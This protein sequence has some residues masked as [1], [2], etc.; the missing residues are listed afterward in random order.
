MLLYARL[1]LRAFTKPNLDHLCAVRG[2]DDSSPVDETRVLDMGC[3]LMRFNFLHGDLIR[4]LGGPYTD[5]HRDWNSVFDQLNAVSECPSPTGYAPIDYSRVYRVCTEGIP[6]KANITASFSSTAERN[7]AP[8]S[9]DLKKNATDCDDKVRAEEKLSYQVLFPRFLWRFIPGLFLCLLR[10][11]YRWGDPKAR[12]CVDPSSTISSSDTGNPNSQIGSPGVDPE[13]NPPIYY[14]TA[15]LRYLVW[16]WNLRCSYPYQ[17]I[18]QMTNDISGAFRRVLYHPDM[19]TMFASVWRHYLV[20]PVG[21]IFGARNSPSF[22]MEKGEMRSHFSQNHPD[23]ASLPLMELTKTLQLPPDPTTEEALQF[24]QAVSDSQ[25]QGIR[26]PYG[27]HPERREPVFVDDSGIAHIKPHFPTAVNCS[28]VSAYVVFGFP[29]ADPNRPPCINPLKWLAIVSFLMLFLGYEIDTRRMLVIWPIPK[30]EKLIIFLTEIIEPQLKTPKEA[31]TPHACTRVLGLLRHAAVVSPMGLYRSL[32]LQFLFNDLVRR[33]PGRALRR[34]YH[35]KIIHLPRDL[36]DE[37][38]AFR[39]SISL[40]R[41]A[42]GWSRLIGL[43]IDRDPTITVYTD[44]S[45]NGLGGWS[46]ETELN[47][48]WR[49]T[50]DELASHGLTQQ[51]GFDNPQYWEEELDPYK[52]HI[53]ILE[54][55]AIFIELWI[56]LRQLE[57]ETTEAAPVRRGIPAGGHRILCMAD[58]TSAVSWLRYAT[59]TRRAVVRRLAQLL[60]AFL[61]HPF[62]SEHVRVQG[63]HL[64]GVDN[65][66]A[67]FL[68]R[69]EK[70]PSWDSVIRAH[71]PLNRL[72]IFPLPPRLLSILVSAIISPQTEAWF[73]ARTT[74]LWTLEL[75]AFVTGSSRAATTPNIASEV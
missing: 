74:E 42:P 71:A 12:L 44:A 70:C 14:G 69:F 31:I 50:I 18:L 35:R 5:A 67:D 29:L 59:R 46:S 60:M 15:F 48:M 25:H 30:R 34:W 19:A 62:P 72:R 16:V 75:P 10:M 21:T 56:I 66:G 55:L 54:F 4:W 6:L 57:W 36:L 20:V 58:N 61:S 40:E 17:D 26:D 47:H 64:R 1:R 53:N 24:Q 49:C 39:Q 2:P 33:A 7:M 8:P 51:S 32:R 73:A 27:P 23:P 68:S 43:I 13:E 52:L 11:A 65:P 9:A 37:L 45:T 63:R 38:V 41:Y 3:A 22:Y 28:V